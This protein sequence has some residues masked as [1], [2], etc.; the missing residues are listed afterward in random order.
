MDID[1][2]QAYRIIERHGFDGITLQ[3][4]KY[5]RDSIGEAY[6]KLRREDL[7]N[8]GGFKVGEKFLISLDNNVCCIDNR[9]SA[10]ARPR[11]FIIPQAPKEIEIIGVDEYNI[12]ES[13]YLFYRIKYKCSC[14]YSAEN[15]CIAEIKIENLKK[16]IAKEEVDCCGQYGNTGE[17]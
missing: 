17:N 11:F 15:S 5:I 10:S 9:Y 4:A 13:H 6:C 14:I 8:R 7:E 3:Q 12:N 16:E 1:V 2:R